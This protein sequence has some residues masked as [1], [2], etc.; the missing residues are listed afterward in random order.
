MCLFALVFFGIGV[1]VLRFLVLTARPPPRLLSA[2]GLVF[3]K[4][5]FFEMGKMGMGS[6]CGGGVGAMLAFLLVGS[7]FIPLGFFGT[8]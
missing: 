3:L 1:L 2:V 4:W 5:G 6:C 7:L 8:G